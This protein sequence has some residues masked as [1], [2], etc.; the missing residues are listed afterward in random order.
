M[1]VSFKVHFST[2]NEKKAGVNPSGSVDKGAGK[3]ALIHY[4]W[5]VN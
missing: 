5:S 2:L 4:R 3:Q 1:P